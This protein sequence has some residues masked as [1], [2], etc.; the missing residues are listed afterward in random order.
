MT[1]DSITPGSWSLAILPDTQHYARDHPETFTAQTEWI[2]DH[3]ASHNIQYVIHVGDVVNNN[4]VNTSNLA[5]NTLQWGRAKTSMDVLDGVVPYAM[6]AGNHDYGP[7]GNSSTRDTYFNDPVYFGPGSSYAMQSNIQ[8]FYELGRT[9]NSYHTFQVQGQDW[10]ILSLEFGPRDEVVSWANDVVTAHAN[11]NAILVTHAYLFHDNQ[12]LDHTLMGHVGYPQEYGI[13]NLPGG[14]NDGQQLWDK[15]VSKHDNFRLTFNGHTVNSSG[16]GDGAGYLASYTDGG[17][18]VHQMLSNYQE[19][20][21]PN[22]GNGYLR[23][24]EFAPNGDVTVRT[25]S[26]TLE[27]HLRIP[28]QEFTFSL[29]SNIEPPPVY[30]IFAENFDH[31]NLPNPAGFVTLAEGTAGSEFTVVQNAANNFIQVERDTHDFFG[32]GAENQ[33]LHFRDAHTGS[34]PAVFAPAGLPRTTS[35]GFRISFDFYHPDD[36][37]LT[38]ANGTRVFLTSDSN[39]GDTSTRTVE[40]R[41]SNTNNSED[42]FG[43]FYALRGSAGLNSDDGYPTINYA[44]DEKHSVVIVGNYGD[45]TITYA[46]GTESV[47][48]GTHDVWLDGVRIWELDIPFRHDFVDPASAFFGISGSSNGAISSAYFDNIEV[49]DLSARPDSVPGDYNRDGHVNIADYTVWRDQLGTTVALIGD[50]ADGNLNGV[51]DAGDYTVWKES[52]GQT[53]SDA[54][55]AASTIPEPAGIL[56]MLVVCALLMVGGKRGKVLATIDVMDNRWSSETKLWK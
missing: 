48:P 6:V 54:S 14:V 19:P 13:A 55:L 42:G 27:K 56:S 43:R 39:V 47:S 7:N 41:L 33:I 2:K 16:G 9:D 26:P 44:L 25:Y 24:L 23:Y 10:L 11:H 51:I 53:S 31:I 30:R 36:G 49:W 17:T 4:T 46:H 1:A 22:G 34:N 5:P 37:T 32:E 40:I 50:G 29:S 8:G 20:L 21:Q 28:G 12:L 35:T 52:F 3:Q 18:L 38:G 15:L 45:E